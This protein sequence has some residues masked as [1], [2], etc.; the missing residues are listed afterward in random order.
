M[1]QTLTERSKPTPAQYTAYNDDWTRT[2]PDLVVHL[3]QEV[4]YASE[5]ADHVLVEVTPGGD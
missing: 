2:E 5:G 1:N 4:T 3:P